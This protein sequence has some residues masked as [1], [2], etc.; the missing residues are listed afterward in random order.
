MALQAEQIE[1]LVMLTLRNLGKG[2][3][4]DLTTDLQEMHFMPKILKEE[5]IQFAGSRGPERY[6]MVKHSGAA[7]HTGLFGVDQ[8]TVGD[9]MKKI[10][11]DWRHTTTYWAYDEREPEINEGPAEL[12]N[13]VKIRRTDAMISLSELMEQT[14]WNNAT[15]FTGDVPFPLW[16]W[17]TKWPTGTSNPQLG[18]FFGLNPVDGSGTTLTTGAGGLSSTTYPRWANY[19]FK[20]TNITKADLIASMRKAAAFTNF[21]PPVEIPDYAR[22]EDRYGI[23]TNYDVVSA[24]EVVGEQQND[25]L[26]RDIARMDG[27]I[28]FHQRPVNWVPI[29][30]AD[31]SDP[32]I[33]LNWAKIYPYFM[34][35]EYLRENKPKDAPDQHRVKHMHIDLTWNTLATSRRCHWVGSKLSATGTTS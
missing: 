32:I 16:Y 22:G 25:N 1:D 7:H 21:K 35:G 10:S 2:K 15:S 8:V 17:V 5:K 3:W 19:A 9:V 20:Y 6:I 28:L 4:E 30:D 12:V 23:Y 34:Q 14:W 31:A 33:G 18:G 27:R 11:A 26:G 24:L 29:L 13:L